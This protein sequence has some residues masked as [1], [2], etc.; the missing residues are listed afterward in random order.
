MAAAGLADD[1]RQDLVTLEKN[2]RQAR[3]EGLRVPGATDLALR[4]QASRRL[5]DD[6]SDLIAQ[7]LDLGG[8]ENVTASSACVH[9]YA[10]VASSACNSITPRWPSCSQLR[11]T[12]V[13]SSP[14]SMR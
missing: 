2:P 12:L 1:G 8:G 9:R 6:G 11:F 7:W 14:G 4:L 5:I 3:L 13:E 10:S